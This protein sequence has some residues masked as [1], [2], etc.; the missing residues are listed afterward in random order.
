MKI[1]KAEAAKAKA[2]AKREKQRILGQPKKNLSTTDKNRIRA[3]NVV[4]E[5]ADEVIEGK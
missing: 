5:A 4:I 3:L 1:S 2:E